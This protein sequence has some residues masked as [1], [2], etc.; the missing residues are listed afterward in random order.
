MTQMCQKLVQQMLQELLVQILPTPVQ[1]CIENKSHII[2]GF[3]GFLFFWRASGQKIGFRRLFEPSGG[4]KSQVADFCAVPRIP[5]RNDRGC[6]RI[7]T[8]R[9]FGHRKVLKIPKFRNSGIPF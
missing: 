5:L 2:A 8:T 9:T 3:F 1:H 7:L 4:D 6:L